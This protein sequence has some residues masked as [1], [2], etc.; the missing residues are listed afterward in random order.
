VPRTL[1]ARRSGPGQSGSSNPFPSSKMADSLTNRQSTGRID[2]LSTRSGAEHQVLRPLRA[3]AGVPVKSTRHGAIPTSI[4]DSSMMI[5]HRSDSARRLRP[6]TPTKQEGQHK[7]R[8]K[9]ADVRHVSDATRLRCAGNGTDAAKKLQNDPDPNDYQRWYLNH[10]LALQYSDL[11]LWEQQNVSAEHPRNR[12]RCS[13][14]RH[15]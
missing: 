2:Q 6:T 13:Q 8:Q 15:V 3:L 9:S 14:I 12:P 7:P 4:L 5:Y 1:S 11:S 10:L